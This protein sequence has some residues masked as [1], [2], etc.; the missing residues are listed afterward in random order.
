MSVTETVT[1]GD[2]AGHS[3][4]YSSSLTR[5]TAATVGGTGEAFRVVSGTYTSSE[6]T[7]SFG[8]SAL[9]VGR[10]SSLAGP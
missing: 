8:N 3:L 9:V 2:E 4:G 10:C 5:F 7:L 6:G 1:P